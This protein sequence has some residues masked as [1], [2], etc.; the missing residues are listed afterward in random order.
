MVVIMETK[1]ERKQITTNALLTSPETV[2]NGC[3]KS[4]GPRYH[5]VLHRF[6]K[7]VIQ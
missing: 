1:K 7:E 2:A 6:S 3:W 5:Q 4:K